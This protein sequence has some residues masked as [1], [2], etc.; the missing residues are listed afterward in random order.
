MNQYFVQNSVGR[1][2]ANAFS[3]IRADTTNPANSGLTYGQLA[4]INAQRIL[5]LA[6]PFA[7]H[8]NQT[9]E[10]LVHL[11]DGQSVGQ[12]R[13]SEYGSPLYKLINYIHLSNQILTNSN[14]GIGG[15]RIPYD[16]NTALM[17]AALR[18]I[19]SLTRNGFFASQPQWAILADQ[20]AQVWEDETLQFFRVTVPQSQAKQLVS[21]YTQTV[22]FPGPNQAD[23]I[24]DDVVFHALALDG[25]DA[26]SQVAVMNTD[27]CFRH[28]LLNTSSRISSSQEQLTE[29]VNQTAN[30][31]RR[32]FPA[33]LRTDA[34]ML[35]SNPAYGANPAYA[36]NWTAGAYH[37]TVVWSWPLAMM[38][39]GLEQQLGRCDSNHNEEDEEGGGGKPR[40]CADHIVYNNLKTA[41]NLLWD[42][43]EA[44][45]A[46][47]SQEVWSWVYNTQ[48]GK[49]VATPLG[50]MPPPPGEASQTG[51][52]YLF[53]II[54][55]YNLAVL[56]STV[57][58]SDIRQLWSLTFL[59]VTR[60][61]AFGL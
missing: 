58:E 54:Y 25:Y 1:S 35:I 46:Q 47:L 20:Y 49:F 39:K 15:G 4:V 55:I 42:S 23:S 24:D 14:T 41:Y 37:G 6:A 16:V 28:F 51:A 53:I 12:W 43:I 26:Q 18:A 5:R 38:A 11:K 59:A 9:Q 13:D 40:F 19:A 30:N 17:P 32:S 44:N 10:N 48:D 27:D 52:F 29:F 60:N 56:T 61:T 31:I 57:I 7:G 2:R 36:A 33:G 21:S 50:V 8:N 45:S 34:G 22:N 3:S